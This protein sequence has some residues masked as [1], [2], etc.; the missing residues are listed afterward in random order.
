MTG[1]SPNGMQGFLSQYF[2]PRLM[3]GMRPGGMPAGGVSAGGPQQALPPGLNLQAL[4]G[5]LG[6]QI[7]GRGG[8]TMGG[9]GGGHPGILPSGGG[10]GGQGG[11]PDFSQL[12]SML[13]GL[14][15]GGGG[16]G[17][18]SSSP[19]LTTP[20][21]VP[22]CPASRRS[23]AISDMPV[24]AVQIL[25]DQLAAAWPALAPLVAL[26]CARSSGRI[27]PADVARDLA[28]G[29]IHLWAGLDDEAPHPVKVILIGQFIDYPRRRS[30]RPFAVVG[31]DRPAWLDLLAVIERWAQAQGATL[32][33]PLGRPGWERVLRDHGYTKT[34]VLMEKVLS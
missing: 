7:A 12:R 10:G 19:A 21:T 14:V 26:A 3:A 18:V 11:R 27:A 8:M 32:I 4:V 25:P 33:E 15:N 24:R 34:H 13:Q 30:F 31:D 1:F 22:R 2:D 16:G 5:A 23:V 17:G 9:A 28:R 20:G 6:A 29:A